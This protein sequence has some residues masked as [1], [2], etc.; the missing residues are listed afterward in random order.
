M[1]IKNAHNG[2]RTWI[3]VDRKA[4]DSNYKIFRNL[5]SKKT[6]L[7]AV[8]KSNAYGHSLIDF[9]REM[10]RLGADWLGVDSIVE[11]LALRREGIKLPILVLGYTFPNR[12]KEAAENDI[13]LTISTFENLNSAQKNNFDLKRPLKVH[14]KIDTGM[15]RQGFLLSEQKT[16]LSK[17]KKPLPKFIIEGLFTHFASAKNPAFPEYT[18]RQ[19]TEFEKWCAAFEK[20]GIKTIMHTGA[21]AGTILFPKA[22]YDMVRV[23]IGLYGLWPDSEIKAFVSHHLNLTPILSW[24]TIVSEVKNVKKG[25]KIGYGL[26]EELKRDSILAVV[27][28]GY[29]HG[30]PRFL[31]SIGWSIIRGKKAK[32]LGR[33]SMDVTVFDVTDIK[34]VRPE[35][36][37]VLIGKQGNQS[38]TIDD[39]L[40]DISDSSYNY[41][42]VTRI[43]PL[44]KRIYI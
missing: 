28:L 20:A 12:F 2:L 19:I 11:A 8:V 44:I 41:E 33:V 34:G 29:W 15:H 23:G 39:E 13:S 6:K 42:F 3:E 18:N 43:N 40:S 24:K 1:N 5:I 4:I 17:F 26:T 31:S 21:T 14:I 36:E 30:Y 9:S 22:H 37:V 25:E 38:I 10:E 32:V 35:H 27:P 7:M 16:L